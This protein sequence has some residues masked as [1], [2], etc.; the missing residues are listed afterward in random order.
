VRFA[1]AW[2]EQQASANARSAPV[3]LLHRWQGSSA[4]VAIEF[5][6]TQARPADISR[7]RCALLLSCTQASV[8]EFTLEMLVPDEHQ[9]RCTGLL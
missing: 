9:G 3:S 8:V 7:T 4:A 6:A 5:H 2:D 1:L